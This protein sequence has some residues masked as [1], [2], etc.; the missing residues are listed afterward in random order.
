MAQLHYTSTTAR[1]RWTL[2]R[3]DKLGVCVVLVLV[4]R[5][6]SGILRVVCHSTTLM[7]MKM[8]PSFFFFYIYGV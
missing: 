6:E 1:V 3:L 7:L 8:V 5:P 2:D 4:S